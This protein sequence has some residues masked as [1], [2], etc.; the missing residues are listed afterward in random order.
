MPPVLPVDSFLPHIVEALKDFE[1][2]KLTARLNNEPGGPVAYV[3]MSGRGRTGARQALTYDLRV[4]GLTDLLR[5]LISVHRTVTRETA[6][7]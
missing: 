6:K 1:F 7:P 4:S 3:S 2:Q 5:E